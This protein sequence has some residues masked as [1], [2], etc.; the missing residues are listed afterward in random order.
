[1][2]KF[3]RAFTLVVLFG[4]ITINAAP[5]LTWSWV[6]PDAYEN[7]DPIIA[8]L[9]TFRLL[10]GTTMGGPYPDS[11]ALD[12]QTPPS[13]QDMQFVVTGPGTYYC[14]STATSSL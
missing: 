10:C 2:K 11:V 6:G 3:L 7:G 5:F 14:V 4:L 13:L 9:L 8:D 12:I 1:M